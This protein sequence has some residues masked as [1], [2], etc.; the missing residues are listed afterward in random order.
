[1]KKLKLTLELIPAQNWGK[2][3]AQVLPKDLWD[4]V[5]R[6]CYKKFVYQCAIC[7]NIGEMHCH[8]VWLYDDKRRIQFLKGVQCL[9]KDCHNIKHWGRMVAMVH[10]GKAKF[11][12]L[13]ML[14]AHF[15]KVNDC[16]LAD[17]EKHKVTMFSL[18]E[19][20]N[21]HNYKLD[22]GKLSPERLEKQWKKSL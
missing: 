17:F 1:M 15:C 5:R 2:S 13:T 4:I 18:N 19:Q 12:E 14:A 10:Q 16:E 3:L 20:R 9:C 6:E 22:W 7:G 11:E 21:R 8:E